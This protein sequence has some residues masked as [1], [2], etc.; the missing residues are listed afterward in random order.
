[1]SPVRTLIDQYV[2]GNPGETPTNVVCFGGAL[3]P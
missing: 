1:M 3:A 2:E